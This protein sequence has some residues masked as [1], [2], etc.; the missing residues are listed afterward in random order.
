MYYQFSGEVKPISDVELS[1][2][3]GEF[4]DLLEV[5]NNNNRS[6]LFQVN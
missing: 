3:V 4:K 1:M 5:N 6:S 2:K